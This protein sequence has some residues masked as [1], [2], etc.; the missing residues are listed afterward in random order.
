MWKKLKKYFS[1]QVQRLFWKG[2]TEESR[3]FRISLLGQPGRLVVKHTPM[4]APAGSPCMPWWDG[5]ERWEQWARRG[6]S[7]IRNRVL[8][9][10]AEC[11]TSPL[12]TKT[13]QESVLQGTKMR[14]LFPLHSW[15]WGK[16]KTAKG[17]WCKWWWRWF[18]LRILTLILMI[19]VLEIAVGVVLLILLATMIVIVLI[20]AF[21]GENMP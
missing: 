4:F 3:H 16:E 7:R 6:K 12:L 15:S 8:R 9:R 10:E 17:I 11:I 13:T 2:M 1:W 21:S 14:L 18:M 20:A 19:R 5:C